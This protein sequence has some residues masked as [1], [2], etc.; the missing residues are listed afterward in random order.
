MKVNAYRAVKTWW[1][2]GTRKLI[3]A[4]T[5]RDD[6]AEQRGVALAELDQEGCRR[7]R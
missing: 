3:P 5:S 1:L 7:S 4:A 2:V 6:E